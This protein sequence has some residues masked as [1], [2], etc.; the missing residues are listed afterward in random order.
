[1]GVDFRVKSNL[2]WQR[3]RSASTIPIYYETDNILVDALIDE[4]H[5]RRV[6]QAIMNSAQLGASVLGTI[7]QDELRENWL[8]NLNKQVDLDLPQN[9]AGVSISREN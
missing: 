1:M 6:Q 3:I 5:T 4:R 7:T 8:R 2:G 9:I